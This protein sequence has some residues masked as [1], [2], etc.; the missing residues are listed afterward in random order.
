MPTSGHP[1]RSVDGLYERTESAS[2]RLTSTNS[3]LPRQKNGNKSCESLGIVDETWKTPEAAQPQLNYYGQTVSGCLDRLVCN[4][5]IGG[6]I[7]VV[8]T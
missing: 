2:A 1:E 7:P 8:S 5:E 4:Q 6:S 3:T